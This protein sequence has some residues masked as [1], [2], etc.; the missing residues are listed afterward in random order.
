MACDVLNLEWSSHGRDRETA[1]LIAATLRRRGYEVVE[2]S[3]FQYRAALA[4]HRPR[5]LYLA[6][7]RGAAI[8]H[9][10]ALFA[11]SRGIPIFTVTAEGNFNEGQI[12]E[13]FWGHVEGGELIEDVN[14]QWSV[15]ARDLALGIDRRMADRLKVAGGVGF[16]RYVLY[17]LTSKEAWMAK[18]GLGFE[19]MVGYASW[20]FDVLGRDDPMATEF[21]SIAG[22]DAVERFTSDRDAVR[23]VLARLADDNPE[24]LF[25]LK[26]HPG[27]V[28]P[29]DTEI[30]GLE[31]RPNVMVVRDEEPVADCISACDV[32]AAFDSTTCLEAWLL[33]KPTLLINPSG[34]DFD[35]TESYRGSPVFADAVEVQAALDSLYSG[36]GLPGFDER[37]DV[38][39][40]ELERA[41]QWDDGRNHLRAAHYLEELIRRAPEPSALSLR[42]RVH[43]LAQGI[44]YRGARWAPGLPL[45]RGFAPARRRFSEDELERV[46][47]R[48]AEAVERFDPDHELTD[49][50]IRELDELNMATLPR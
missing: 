23:V 39:R 35:R 38:R 15:R 32:W 7:P 10:A 36:A 22:G 11:R 26:E 25:L 29:E 42:D 9:R 40:E 49:A 14:A 28:V 19:R 2:E 37:A 20:V 8:N 5:V 3:V 16:D 4:R 41:I 45:F 18:H 17:E 30:A 50:E 34:E 12:A 6:D 24:T 13:L 31:T 44:L 46:T 33:G 48:A 21:R 47:R 43:G 27:V 1:S